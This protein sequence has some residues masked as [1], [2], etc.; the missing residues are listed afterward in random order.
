MFVLQNAPAAS[1]W[2]CPG[3]D[4][5]RRWSAE[6]RHRQVRPD[7]VA[8]PRRA[9]GFAGALEYNTDLFDAGHRGAAWSSTCACCWRPSSPTRTQR[10]VRAAAAAPRPSGSSCWWSGTTPRAD[11][12]R[13][14]L[15]ARSCSRPRRARTP[16]AAGR[17][18]S[19]DT[20]AHLRA[21]WTRAPTSWRA[22][23]ARWASGPRCRVAPVPGALAGAGRRRCSASSRP[24]APTCR[25]TRPT[26]ASAWPSC[27][28]TAARRVLLTQRAPAR[29]RCP[30]RR[31]HV[32]LPGRR[33]GGARARSPTHAPRARRRPGAPGLRHLHLRLHRPA[34]GRR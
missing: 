24:A 7:A 9:E 12:P 6:H 3:L 11:F 33:G 32:V 13:D 15:R 30:P 28:R 19:R 10:A 22:T 2:R 20:H 16:D 4:A 25:W 27:S 1:R 21:S 8:A 14:A 18:R 31:A 17:A 5:A 29:T 34:Q 23:C 26:R